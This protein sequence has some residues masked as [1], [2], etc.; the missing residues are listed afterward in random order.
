MPCG[1]R[2][3]AWSA[4]SLGGPALD[5]PSDV[6]SAESITMPITASGTEWAISSPV[7]EYQYLLSSDA[8]SCPPSYRRTDTAGLKLAFDERFRCCELRD[9]N[10]ALFGTLIGFAYD[11][12]DRRFL[13]AG[14]ADLPIEIGDLATFERDGDPAAR[15]CFPPRH[16]RPAT[17]AYLSRPRRIAADRVLSRGSHRRGVAQ[18]C[19]WTMR[20][21]RRASIT[22]S[23]TR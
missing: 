19:S 21:M 10:G 7:S 2:C 15:R 1:A 14:R 22:V 4:L 5:I 23:T 17:A 20:P 13:G 6:N 12:Q 9:V 18:R 3:V 16:T 8:V 11:K